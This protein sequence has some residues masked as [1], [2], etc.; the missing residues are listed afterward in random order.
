VGPPKASGP[1]GAA[2]I[3][4]RGRALRDTFIL[5]FLA[6]DRFVRG[7]LLVALAYGIWRFDGSDR[8]PAPAQIAAILPLIGWNKVKWAPPFVTL[9]AGMEIDFGGLAKEYAVDRAVALA[10][11]MLQRAADEFG[12]EESAALQKV[13]EAAKELGLL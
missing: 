6:A 11:K 12:A 7:S 9:G 5:R 3:V 4:L 2:P 1:A 13:V 10:A 8:V